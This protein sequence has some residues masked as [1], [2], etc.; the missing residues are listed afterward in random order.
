[1]TD[2]QVATSL[3]STTMRSLPVELLEAVLGQV[4]SQSTLL[5]LRASNSLF[6]ILATPLAFQSISLINS[7]KSLN[8]FHHITDCDN[9]A[10]HIHQ[11]VY[12]YEEADPST[13]DLGVV[14]LRER[15]Y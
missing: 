10:R 9:L 15:T 12:Q 4:S 14:S 6:Y 8:R 11:V 3:S 2:F 5:Q 7:D 1:M 13:Y